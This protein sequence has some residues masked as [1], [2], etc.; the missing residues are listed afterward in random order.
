MQALSILIAFTMIK[1]KKS[2]DML[3][4]ISKLDYLLKISIFQVYKDKSMI[5]RY[6]IDSETGQTTVKFRDLNTMD[7]RRDESEAI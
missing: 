7:L 3:Q 6:S 4:G 2:D 5:K 1:L